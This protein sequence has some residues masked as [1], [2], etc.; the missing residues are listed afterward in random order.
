MGSSRSWDGTFDSSREANRDIE[1]LILDTMDGNEIGRTT[2]E[3]KPLYVAAIDD[4]YCLA[5]DNT[6][7]YQ[8]NFE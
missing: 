2:T 3:T 8:L 7:L 5:I 6:K 1:D 4:E